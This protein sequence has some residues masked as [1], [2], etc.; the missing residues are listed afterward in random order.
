MI[1]SRERKWNFTRCTI[2]TQKTIKNLELIVTVKTGRLHI[3][4]RVKLKLVMSKKELMSLQ[5]SKTTQMMRKKCHQRQGKK[6]RKQ[7]RN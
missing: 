4:F 7:R 3:I 5:I 6:R 2:R 1:S